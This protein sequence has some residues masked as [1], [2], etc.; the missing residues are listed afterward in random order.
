MLDI[1]WTQDISGDELVRAL[2]I[3][4]KIPRRKALSAL[5]DKVLA[6]LT[7]NGYVT[8]G[9]VQGTADGL[10]DVLEDE[11][12][13]EVV[14]VDGEVDEGDVHIKPVSRKFPLLVRL[15]CSCHF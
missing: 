12:E 5:E 6:I 8:K 3:K 1:L 11:D 15:I 4:R 2:Q 9:E 13:D 10:V 14:V 7:E